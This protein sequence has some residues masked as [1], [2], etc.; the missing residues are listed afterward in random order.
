MSITLKLLGCT[1][2]DR[3]GDKGWLLPSCPNTSQV[4]R[5][6]RGPRGERYRRFVLVSTFYRYPDGYRLAEVEL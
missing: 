5:K 3:V 1:A 4:S 6:P 2:F